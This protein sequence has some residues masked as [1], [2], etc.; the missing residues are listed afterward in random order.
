MSNW[1]GVICS[2]GVK[3]PATSEETLRE[4]AAAGELVAMLEEGKEHGGVPPVKLSPG[5]NFLV[6]YIDSEE[7]WISPGT[8]GG[9]GLQR[10]GPWPV[11]RN[12]DEAAILRGKVTQFLES[13]TASTGDARRHLTT[14]ADLVRALLLALCPGPESLRVVRPLASKLVP[15]LYFLERIEHEDLEVVV[16]HYRAEEFEE[17]ARQSMQGCDLF[18]MSKPVAEC[19]RDLAIAST[20]R[21][22]AQLAKNALRKFPPTFLQADPDSDL[23][24]A[25][26][27]V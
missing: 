6:G 9:D 22:L 8:F 12:E 1:D 15:A 24:K 10:V 23:A 5:G 14:K 21:N 3:T 27:G 4:W 26:R 16:G 20:D 25:I 13:I 17:L 2:P 19:L 18:A 11:V 7:R